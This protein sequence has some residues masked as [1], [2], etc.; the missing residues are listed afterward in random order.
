[1]ADSAIAIFNAEQYSA[2]FKFL[3]SG[4][5]DALKTF[6]I[7]ITNLFGILGGQIIPA[8][9]TIA[10]SFLQ[11]LA[12]VF[13]TLAKDF[14]PI[15]AFVVVVGII[16]GIIFASKKKNEKKKKKKKVVTPPPSGILGLF[17]S[18]ATFDIGSFF[19]SFTPRINTTTLPSFFGG[20]T[21]TPII[22][23]SLT[24]RSK[25]T[26]RCDN[27]HNY[28]TPKSNICS[29]TSTPEPIVWTL[30]IE[31]MPELSELSERTKHLVDGGADAQKYMVTI[32]WGT[33]ESDGFHYY[34]DCRKAT[35]GNGES[36]AYL[37]TDNG[38][39]SCEKKLVQ[40]T[41]N[42]A[43]RRPTYMNPSRTSL[44]GYLS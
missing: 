21:A 33:Y 41:I 20:E 29:H 5:G 9:S 4:I 15:I 38:K 35:F 7:Q 16:I 13:G 18:F 30:D 27:L 42:E 11:A 17:P 23:R 6:F 34:P 2:L 3:F 10:A 44:D 37:F 26:G 40:R 8:F 43:R 36:A 28:T 25:I 32:P 39:N 31:K 14:M 24:D 19:G 22:D 12:S 1:M